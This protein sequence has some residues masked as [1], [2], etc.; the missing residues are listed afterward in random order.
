MNTAKLSANKLYKKI[1]WI[2]C[3]AHCSRNEW[4]TPDEWKPVIVDHPEKNG[5]MQRKWDG[6]KWNETK[7]VKRNDISNCYREM[8]VSFLSLS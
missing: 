6:I 1:E 2:I 8:C 3:N 7:S 5:M 4:N